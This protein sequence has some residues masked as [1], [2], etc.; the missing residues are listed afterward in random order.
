[1]LGIVFSMIILI[2]GLVADNGYISLIGLA[3]LVYGLF[4]YMRR[5]I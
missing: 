5:V 2:A 4:L 1:M 3:L